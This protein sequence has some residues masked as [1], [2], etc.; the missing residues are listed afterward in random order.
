VVDLRLFDRQRFVQHLLV[1]GQALLIV[2]QLLP[3]LVAAELGAAQ[4]LPVLQDHARAVLLAPV[5]VLGQPDVPCGQLADLSQGDGHPDAHT[6]QVALQGVLHLA[7]QAGAV[8]ADL[9]QVVALLLA[10]E[11]EGDVLGEQGVYLFQEG[12][13]HVGD[14]DQRRHKV[15][16]AAQPEGL[17][18]KLERVLVLPQVD[19]FQAEVVALPPELVHLDGV[20]QHRLVLLGLQHLHDALV[21]VQL[22]LAI[23]T[24][25]G[26][27]KPKKKKNTTQLK[28]PLLDVQLNTI[29]SNV[30]SFTTQAHNRTTTP[31]HHPSEGPWEN[32]PHAR[33]RAHIEEE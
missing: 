6:V 15:L 22:G 10:G 19:G 26:E 32:R 11:L 25:R 28:R 3:L 14:A 31:N 7:G 17:D 8:A 4:L 21:V 13:G 27:N 29:Q 2:Q 30:R 24:C 16:L 5:V 23:G 33:G 20:L 18:L 9:L 12:S 1:P